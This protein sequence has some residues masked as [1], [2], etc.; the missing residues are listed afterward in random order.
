M[1]YLSLFIICACAI[2]GFAQTAAPEPGT[3][4]DK[5]DV[6]GLRSALTTW[7]LSR[8]SQL[9]SLQEGL[10]RAEQDE[11]YRR[12]LAAHEILRTA[13]DESLNT[14]LSKPDGSAFL[15]VF[16]NDTAWMEEYLVRA[17]N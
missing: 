7:L 11:V 13:G 3:Y 12:A 4:L 10:I 5:R 15:R 2:N 16:L 9:G 17:G 14:L 6:T 1:R 8:E